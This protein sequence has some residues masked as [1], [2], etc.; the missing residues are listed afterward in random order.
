MSASESN[1]RTYISAEGLQ[2]IAERVVRS[3]RKALVRIGE[4]ISERDAYSV[5][6]VDGAMFVLDHLGLGPRQRARFKRE[7]KRE[8]EEYGDDASAT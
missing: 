7:I 4:G 1:I 8:R 6:M 5:G 2:R 3:E